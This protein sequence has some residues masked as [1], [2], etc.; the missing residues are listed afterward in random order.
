MFF[1]RN[2]KDK[3]KFSAEKV[4]DIG[5]KSL[6]VLSKM[7]EIFENNKRISRGISGKKKEDLK[8]VNDKQGRKLRKVW[9]NLGECVKFEENLKRILK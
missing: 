4:C 1:E 2:L 3:V 7:E 5:K 9:E 8:E 6:G